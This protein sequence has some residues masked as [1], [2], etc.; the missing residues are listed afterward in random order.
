[1]KQRQ[2]RLLKVPYFQARRVDAKAC[3]PTLVE[4]CNACSSF[5][6]TIGLEVEAADLLDLMAAPARRAQLQAKVAKW[7]GVCVWLYLLL[8]AFC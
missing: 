7:A 3:F 8:V 1:M 6:F 2:P 5:E 4:E